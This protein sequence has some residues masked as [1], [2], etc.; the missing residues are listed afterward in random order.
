MRR[1]IREGAVQ[2][3]ASDMPF[4]GGGGDGSVADIVFDADHFSLR[5]TIPRAKAVA[6]DREQPG[7]QARSAL[8]FG[9]MS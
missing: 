5:N 8:K 1:E 9:G 4:L 3:L 2:F 6:H 7:F